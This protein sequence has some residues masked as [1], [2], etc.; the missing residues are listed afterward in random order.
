MIARM[1]AQR[2]NVA[3]PYLAD[4]KRRYAGHGNHLD[5]AGDILQST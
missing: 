4:I 5:M 2:L 3:N 1:P